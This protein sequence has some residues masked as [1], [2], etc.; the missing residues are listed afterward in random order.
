MNASPLVA[1]LQH[2]WQAESDAP[3][4]R[5]V[6]FHILMVLKT[7]YG[8]IDDRISAIGRRAELALYSRANS[9][10][11]YRNPR[12]L[13]M[14]LHA[15]IIKLYAHQ[16]QTSR[17][18]KAESECEPVPAKK[19]KAAISSFIL[20]GHDG[21]LRTVCAFLDTPSVAALAATN[22]AAQSIVPLHVTSVTLTAN[23]RPVSPNWLSRFQNLESLRLV[24]SNRFGFGDVSM[25]EVD[26]S[27]NSAALWALT[28]LEQNAWPYLR[29][30]EMTHVYCDGLHDPITA[31]VAAL[32]ASLPKL[33]T[34]ALT[35][36]CISDV[37]ALQ[38]A[39]VAKQT[40]V[41]YLDGNF[42]GERGA[43]ALIAATPHVSLENNLME[44][45]AYER[46]FPN[47][48]MDDRYKPR[49]PVTLAA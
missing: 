4:R 16:H 1:H 5:F 36:N 33:V 11:E 31:R 29:Y 17:K 21:A 32:M 43:A 19:V 49:M 40:H 23:H 14:R 12:T 35:G 7:K 13:C 34:V 3:A 37:G 38:L 48:T 8:V 18:R 24:G 30:L 25:D 26:M 28:G 44:C 27:S 9:L 20:D 39:T 41:F 15:L 46:L 42:I 6:L 45:A 10:T 47:R 22:R 2:K